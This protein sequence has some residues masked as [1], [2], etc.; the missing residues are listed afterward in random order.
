MFVSCVLDDKGSLSVYFK[1]VPDAV[2]R[3][4]FA[5]RDTAESFPRHPSHWE[6][7]NNRGIIWGIDMNNRGILPG[8]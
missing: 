7:I 3:I 2:P 6:E 5:I 1:T 8:G 4:I